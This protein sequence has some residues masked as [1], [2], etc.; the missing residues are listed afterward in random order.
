M[1][2]CLH[3]L[4]VRI[5]LHILVSMKYTCVVMTSVLDL[6]RLHFANCSIILKI[7]KENKMRMRNKYRKPTTLRCNA[8][9][10]CTLSVVVWSLVGCLIMLHLYS[11]VYHKAVVSSEIEM[12]AIHHPLLRELEEVEEEENIRIPP[13][14]KRSPRAEK[15][16]PR[17][18][19][20]IID[21]FLDES[22]QLRRVFFPNEKTAMNPMKGDGNMSFYYYPGRIWLDTEGN[23]IQAHGGGILYDESSGTY[24]WYGEYKDGPTYHA[25]K[26]AAA[27]VCSLI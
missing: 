18:P 24:Y 13:P 17:R 25:H 23:P 11:I 20:T 6:P 2:D 7:K 15:R 21:E 14:R 19:T 22:S 9:S 4:P 16:K 3:T 27:R 1:C 10:R 8:G 5:Y 12:R 26:K